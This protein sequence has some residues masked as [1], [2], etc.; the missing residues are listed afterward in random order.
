MLGIAG[1]I[2]VIHTPGHSSGHVSLLWK[3]DRNVLLTGDAVVNVPRLGYTVAY[4]DFQTGKQSAAKLAQLDFEVAVFGHGKPI[5]SN[6]SA[7]FAKTFH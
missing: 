5:L 4:D 6:A 3:S 7:R 1:G 2:E